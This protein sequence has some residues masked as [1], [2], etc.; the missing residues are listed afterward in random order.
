MKKTLSLV[1]S[2]IL[3]VQLLAVMPASGAT[4]SQPPN[5]VQAKLTGDKLNISWNAVAGAQSYK[6]Y[7][8][9][10]VTKKYE[11]IGS[12]VNGE[13]SY[14]DLVGVGG[15]TK[16]TR[17]TYHVTATDS[18]GVESKG[19][20]SVSAVY[21]KNTAAVP[22]SVRAVNASDKILLTWTSAKDAT[23]YKVYR[24][25]SKTGNAQ[26]ISGPVPL[27]ATA[28]TDVSFA[29]LNVKTSTPVYYFVTAV[30]RFNLE[31]NKSAAVM[32]LKLPPAVPAK[33]SASYADG[34]VKLEWQASP[35]AAKYKVHW[36]TS[37]SS[38]L[39]TLLSDAVTSTAFTVPVNRQHVIKDTRYYYAVTAVDAWEN[40]SLPAVKSVVIPSNVP[41]IPSKVTALNENNVIHL[42][43]AQATNATQ[44]NVYRSSSVKGPFTKVNSAP[45]AVNQFADSS[46]QD[47]YV[48][49]DKVYYY[50]ISSVNPY[51]TES[52]KSTPV[53]VVLKPPSGPS[54]IVAVMVDHQ[55]ELNW[56]S[57]EGSS[58][59]HIYRSDS[60]ETGFTL[61]DRVLEP[62]Y[63]DASVAV[64]L[65][66]DK[67]QYYIIAALDGQGRE[68]LKSSPAEVVLP[69]NT[70][71]SPLSLNAALSKKIV[72]LSWSSSDGAAGY[73][74]YR[75]V[76]GTEDY[77][78]LT[79]EPVIAG[80][81]F[82]DNTL[83]EQFYTENT[84]YD[85]AVTAI[86]AY[87]TESL[88]STPQSVTLKKSLGASVLEGELSQAVAKLNWS[89]VDGAVGY[90]VYR[91]TQD[92]PFQLI[93]E[94][95]SSV[96]WLEQII[97]A[98]YTE[99]TTFTYRISAV[100][101]EALESDYSNKVT[102]TMHS[103]VARVPADLKAE[104]AGKEVRLT[105]SASEQAQ[106][107]NIYRTLPGSDQSVLANVYGPVTSLTF[108][109]SFLKDMPITA[110]IKLHYQVTANNAYGTESASSAPV[111]AVL[112]VPVTLPP[113]NAG[114][115]P[116]N[117]LVNPGFELLTDASVA[118]GWTKFTAAGATADIQRTI[119]P[120]DSGK[121]AMKIA[122][123]AIPLNGTVMISQ[124]IPVPA[125]KPYDLSASL[126]IE[127]L[128]N[129]KVQVFV[130][131]YNAQNAVVASASAESQ[132]ATGAYAKVS[133]SAFIPKDAATARVYTI[134]RA[135]G[136][137]GSGKL[138]VDNMAFAIS[139]N[140]VL[141]PDFETEGSNNVAEGWAKF[142]PAGALTE[143]ALTGEQVAS[144][145]K[146][147]KIVTSMLPNQGTAMVSQLFYVQ[148]NQPYYVSSQL[149][150][151]QLTNAKAQLF[152][153]FYDVNNQVVGSANVDI[154]SPTQ[155][156]RKVE[157]IGTIPATATS[158]RVYA[159]IRAIAEQGSGSL[160]VDQFKFITEGIPL[161]NGSFEN[162]SATTGFAEGWTKFIPAGVTG[163]VYATESP[164]TSGTSA[165]RLSG[166]NMASGNTIMAWQ[167]LPVQG[168]K[169]YQLSGN[170]NLEHIQGSQA[171]LFINFYNSNNQIVGNTSVDVVSAT[172]GFVALE[173]SGTIP[174]TAVQARV[175]AILRSGSEHGSGSVVVDDLHF[176][177]TKWMLKNKDFEQY[178]ANNGTADSWIPYASQGVTGPQWNKAEGQV[179]SGQFAQSL[180]ATDLYPGATVMISQIVTAEAG[181]PYRLGGDLNVT[182]LHH[183]KAQLFVNFYN[184]VNQ[185]VG[186]GYIDITSP[187]GG[188]VR[189]DKTG[190]IPAGTTTARVYV[191]L[192]GTG[193]DGSGA[194][195]A[196]QILFE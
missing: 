97:G 50:T 113:S 120:V 180:A 111:E 152:V 172:N 25:L 146:A 4:T 167:L 192:T 74:V 68:S 37:A 52:A 7:R 161:M 127:E 46:L 100:E 21:P 77:V 55:V 79:P 149:L 156:Y 130:N 136:D 176:A 102:F 53:S 57:K 139:R 143:F 65:P 179:V 95:P 115:D 162:M 168:G 47:L 72:S 88:M 44:Y 24:A 49:S 195:Y 40:N 83:K 104:V 187:N 56:S 142:A 93:A 33:L 118:D 86:S 22:G 59:Y 190:I 19:S 9:S 155:R 16:D 193:S 69:K 141:N 189:Y 12:P 148:P 144:G 159:M 133:K 119:A 62:P 34:S 18:A 23:G 67:K 177:T 135:T 6:V 17:F 170:F 108:T 38:P 114:Q 41:A 194:L 54:G 81:S 138:Y 112:N 28:Y 92:A 178:T 186:S 106:A 76:S 87:G 60:K 27:T 151:E 122:A 63:T 66:K 14:V 36:S 26:L 147:Q 183:A 123:T 140:A 157:K 184:N 166:E 175:Y 107:Y 125:G 32:I 8:Y 110:P 70:A 35:G 171:Q 15:I 101:E 58:G 91:Q 29:S 39:K 196:D 20:V 164:I 153:N 124:L 134:L 31:S 80:T 10:N 169:P 84:L 3:A 64:S 191:L 158:A 30:D 85:Y 154:L 181:R 78:L 165:I 96:R 43:W 61:L 182:S 150:A 116:F 121:Y 73:K 117:H 42:S 75:K 90:K 109:D 13:L 174:L 5:S 160:F 185:V 11:F 51:Q 99:D 1:L 94:L 128:T 129:A 48:T 132:S 173:K 2:I 82:T 137:Q 71:D 105:W 145:A 188:Y 98:T 163:N 45:V 126:R 131:F 89:A 103:N